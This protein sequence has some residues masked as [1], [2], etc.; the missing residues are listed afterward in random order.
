MEFRGV[1][2]R[3]GGCCGRGLQRGGEKKAV[4]DGDTILG[5][6]HGW[7]R[8]PGLTCVGTP[9]LCTISLSI[10]LQWE[11][12]AVVWGL[13]ATCLVPKFLVEWNE[14]FQ[15]FRLQ[16]LERGDPVTVR[17]ALLGAL[18][19]GAAAVASL[20]RQFAILFAVIS[21]VT[22]GNIGIAGKFMRKTVF[23]FIIGCADLIF[24]LT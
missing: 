5:V 19:M 20:R 16:V 15:N 21:S 17:T 14:Y 22:R 10:G 13:A 9:A 1:F 8:V 24:D 11:V 6:S 23:G 2:C 12:N 3:G 7:G 4:F 18:R